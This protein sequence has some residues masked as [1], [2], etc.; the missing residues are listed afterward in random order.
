[1][2]TQHRFPSTVNVGMA[3]AARVQ[4][5][6]RNGSSYMRTAWTRYETEG[7]DDP[8]IRPGTGA[9]RRIQL[10]TEPVAQ[11]RDLWDRPMSGEPLV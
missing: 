8:E 2:I 5:Q 6:C 3:P 10:L 4:A 1:M 9:T 7:A 11:G